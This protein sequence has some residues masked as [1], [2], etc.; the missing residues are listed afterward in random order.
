MVTVSA[1]A[2]R[3]VLDEAEAAPGP[4]HAAHLSHG[5]LARGDGAEGERADNRVEA[6]VGK[7]AQVGRVAARKAERVPCRRGRLLRGG[8]GGRVRRVDVDGRHLWAERAEAPMSG[9][10]Y[11]CVEGF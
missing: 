6:A 5:R 2:L 8:E 10:L 7:G 9:T 3:D 4:E 11:R 1:S